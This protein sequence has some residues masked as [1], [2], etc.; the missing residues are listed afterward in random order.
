MK[1]QCAKQKYENTKSYFPKLNEYMNQG[2]KKKI[3]GNFLLHCQAPI[4]NTCVFFS[5]LC[6]RY[7][8]RRVKISRLVAWLDLTRFQMTCILLLSVTYF[9]CPSL[10]SCF[11]SI[12]SPISMYLKN[13]TGKITWYDATL[14]PVSWYNWETRHA[15]NHDMMSHEPEK[16]R[17]EDLYY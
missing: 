17:D 7:L 8:L 6:K 4:Y 10:L 15:N 13:M 12:S 5:H 3:L 11:I 1:D 14:S 16:S 9:R 2:D